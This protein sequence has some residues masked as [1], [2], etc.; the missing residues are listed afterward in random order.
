MTTLTLVAKSTSTT[1]QFRSEHSWACCTVN[2][3]TG[4]LNIQSDWGNWSYR[5][6]PDPKHL[7]APSLTQFIADRGEVDYIARKLQG[8]GRNGQRWSGA[9]TA[10]ALQK[11]L[12][13]RRF[14]DGRCQ[15]E[16]RLEPE[17]LI[18]GEVPARL[19]HD[20]TD[21]GL[22]IYSADFP[23]DTRT[24]GRLPF[25]SK[26]TARDL[27]ESIGDLGDE[28]ERSSDLFYERVL[29]I[30]GFTDYVTG[31]PWEY[32]VT[33]Q[34]LEDRYLRR[35]VIPALIAACREAGAAPLSSEETI[36]GVVSYL[37][38]HADGFADAV[39]M[40]SKECET[41]YALTKMNA[42]RVLAD[43]IEAGEWA[44]RSEAE[45]P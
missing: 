6:S 8:E 2:D 21:D 9:A 42:A 41:R 28:I 12:C 36:R 30:D 15:L 43:R 11:R 4:E 23:W 33:E 14:N 32:A 24:S 44:K 35:F 26:D 27:F 34:T 17:D 25:L 37:R 31:E 7:G 1:Y 38:A 16:N 3:A 18:D 5:W 29:Q 19:R 13:E 40:E 45:Q 20:Y 22:P 10:K 39:A